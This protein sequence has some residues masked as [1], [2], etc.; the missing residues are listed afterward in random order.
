MWAP[1]YRASESERSRRLLS[2]P[3]NRWTCACVVEVAWMLPI[4]T[5]YFLRTVQLLGAPLHCFAATC[6]SYNVWERVRI[7]C[8]RKTVVHPQRTQTPRHSQHISVFGLR[9]PWSILLEFHAGHSLILLVLQV[10]HGRFGASGRHKDRGVGVNHIQD[11][12]VGCG[13]RFH[14]RETPDGRI[15]SRSD[16]VRRGK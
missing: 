12:S 3:D 4:H 15:G 7:L 16:A 9:K 11:D 2:M 5:G 1:R 10:K 13:G 14:Y 6:I 8:R